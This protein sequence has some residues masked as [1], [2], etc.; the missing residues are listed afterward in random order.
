MPEHGDGD[1]G[2]AGAEV[3]GGRDAD[4]LAELAGDEGRDRATAE[5]HEA[6]GGGGH[7]PLDRRGLHDHLRHQGV[8]D[9]E[10]GARDDDADD[11]RRLRGMQDAH[12]GEQDGDARERAGQAADVAEAPRDARRHEDGEHGQ[13]HAPAAEDVAELVGAQA[14][15]EGRVGQQGEEAEVVEDRDEAAA[16]RGPVAQ[17]AQR[18]EHRDAL[19]GGRAG[20]VQEDLRW[21]RGRWS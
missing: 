7:G 19:A 21:P 4:V 1:R 16:A 5:A 14:E 17:G 9:A 20:A 18:V 11:E 2:H 15:R 6:V 13:H 12:D 3:E 10:E 8:G